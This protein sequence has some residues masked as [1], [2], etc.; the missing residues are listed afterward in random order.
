MATQQSTALYSRP[1]VAITPT[2][3]TIDTTDQV[4]YSGT[5]PIPAVNYDLILIFVVAT[6]TT[7]TATLSTVSGFSFTRVTSMTF[8]GGLDSIYVF[9]SNT[10]ICPAT[11]I[12]PDFSATGDAATG[13]MYFP[14]RIKNMAKTGS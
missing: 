12:A 13:F 7:A 8:N 5:S 1:L 4:T 6:D 10:L 9:I 3:A 2:T 11:T 14:F